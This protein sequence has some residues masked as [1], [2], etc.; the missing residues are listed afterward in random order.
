MIIVEVISLIASFGTCVLAFLVWK[1]K[2]DALKSASEHKDQQ[3]ESDQSTEKSSFIAGI[4]EK[5]TDIL[6]RMKKSESKPSSEEK[7]DDQKESQK[8][9]PIVDIQKKAEEQNESSLT[10]DNTDS[11]AESDKK[12]MNKLK[13]IKVLLLC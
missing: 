6:A 12:Q 3:S 4:R 11:Q 1:T 5:I 2:S 9:T 10:K 7:K 8:D 13:K